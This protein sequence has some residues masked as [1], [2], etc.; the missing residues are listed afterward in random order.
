MAIKG[1]TSAFYL[2]TDKVAG[3][4]NVSN[5]IT[6]DTLDVTTFDSNCFR[7]FLGGLRNGTISIIGFYEPGDTTGQQALFTALKNGEVLTAGQ[8]PKFMMSPSIGFTADGVVSS[9]EVSASVDQV[10]T[11]SATIQLSG[12]IDLV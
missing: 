5:P 6:G 1:C 11:F 12:E 10:I 2:G 4:N 3:L 9:Y 7:E 8:K